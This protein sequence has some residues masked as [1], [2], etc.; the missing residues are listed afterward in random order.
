[1]KINFK[2]NIRQIVLGAVAVVIFVGVLI[3]VS[4]L[5]ANWCLTPLPGTPTNNCTGSAPVV[6]PTLA[7]GT[8]AVGATPVLPTDV[9]P[10]PAGVI[11]DPWD[12]ASRITVLVMGLD[13]SDLSI[14]GDRIGPARSDSMILLTVDPQTNTAAMLSVPRDLWTNIPGFGYAKINTAYYDGDADKLPG[15]GP[16]L[17]VKTVEQVMGVPIQ[18]YAQIDFW[19]FRQLVD[20][21]GKIDVNVPKKMIIDP[22]GAG[23][24]HI[25][26]HQGMN[27]LSGEKALAYVR[28]RHTAGGDVDRSQRQQDV[29]IAIRNKVMDPANFP[30][31]ISHSTYL[32]NDIQAGVHTDMPL[33]VAVRLA[34]LMKDLPPQNIK[35]VVIDYT[36]VTLGNVMVDG[37]NE[38]VMKPIPDKIRELRDQVFGSGALSPLAK[39]TDALDLA[40]QEGATVRVL[41]GTYTQGLANATADYLKGLGINV[42]G[43]D[44]ANQFPSYSIVIDHRGRPYML[45]YMQGLLHLTGGNQ[46]ISQYDPAAGADIDIILGADWAQNNPMP[47]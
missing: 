14:S 27:T 3:G 9:V 10:A 47:K 19:A 44:S 32:Y 7:P 34:V 40:K 28:D 8:Q 35:H 33:D 16:A 22:E 13:S 1:M 41:N 6:G 11:P 38:N 18:Y 20:D 42:V 43:T 37:T 39:G 21:L 2:P 30:G 17:A 26:L 5:V 46:I 23:N 12:G 29:I 36:M 24:D 25:L 31:F 15:G 4:S 45:K